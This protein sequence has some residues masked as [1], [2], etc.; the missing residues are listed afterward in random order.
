MHRVPPQTNILGSRNYHHLSRN[1]LT[2]LELVVEKLVKLRESLIV[3]KQD[4]TAYVKSSTVLRLYDRLCEYAQQSQHLD[5]FLEIS[6]A[7]KCKALP[8]HLRTL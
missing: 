7:S 4:R 8:S 6:V 1:M 5:D 2:T 3:L